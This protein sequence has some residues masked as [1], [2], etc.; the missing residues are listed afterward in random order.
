MDLALGDGKRV[1]T[2]HFGC[3]RIKW[4]QEIV[5]TGWKD[6]GSDQLCACGPLPESVSLDSM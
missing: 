4:F 5:V 3:F 1:W 2:P 6:L